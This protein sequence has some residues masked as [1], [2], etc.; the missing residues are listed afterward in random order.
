MT[1]AG[2]VWQGVVEGLT[3]LLL[4]PCN[5]TFSIS[6][7][8]CKQGNQP[9]FSSILWSILSVNARSWLPVPTMICAGQVW[10]GVVEGLTTLFLEPCNGT[11]W[12]GCIY[13]RNDDA[14]RFGFFCGAALEY[15]NNHA[16]DLRCVLMLLE[17]GGKVI[18]FGYLN[19]CNLRCVIWSSFTV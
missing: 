6:Q 1:C 15:L 2:Q 4:E 9:Q 13:G 14:P 12:V 8:L 7:L 18:M 5:G 3:T 17:L 10:Q 11:F 16:G 19:A